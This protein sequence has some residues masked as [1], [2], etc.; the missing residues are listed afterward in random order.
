MN[1]LQK[2]EKTIEKNNSLLCI[3]LDSDIAKIP[4]HLQSENDPL[5]IFNKAIIDATSDLVCSYKLN[6]AFYEARG[7]NG[8]SEMKKTINYIREAYPDIP[9]IADAKRGDIGNTSEMYARALFDEYKF[10]ATTVNPYSG[11]DS[12]EPFFKYADKGII[13][14]CRTSNPGAKDFQD[15]SVNGKPLYQVVAEKVGQWNNQ[16]NNCLLVVGATAPEDL[17]K[18]RSIVPDMFFLVPGIGAQGGDLENSLKAGLTAKKTGLLIHSAR[19]ILYASSGQDF[20]DKAKQEAQKL[21]D[22]INTFRT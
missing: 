1:F 15:V 22:Q 7:I 19:G 16:Y 11:F 9:I 4:P 17:A 5:F 20:A 10:D 8:A 12:L 3:G 18:V 6:L 13:V 2:L 14:L 21:K